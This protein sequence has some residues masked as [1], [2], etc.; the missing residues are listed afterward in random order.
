VSASV[1]LPLRH[2]VEKFSSGTRW[3]WKKGRKM[4]V[5]WF[6]QYYAKRLARN[7]VSRMTYF[8]SSGGCKSLTRSINAN[9]VEIENWPCLMSVLLL[10]CVFGLLN[11]VL[12]IY[13]YCLLYCLQSWWLTLWNVS[14]LCKPEHHCQHSFTVMQ[15]SIWC[16]VTAAIDCD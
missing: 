11:A 16:T 2:K 14:Q 4:V 9:P 15:Y 12:L 6:L 5:A 1:N 7:N 3:S 10:S 13:L 8:V